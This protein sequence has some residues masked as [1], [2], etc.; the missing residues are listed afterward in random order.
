MASQE[1]TETI[2]NKFRHLSNEA[3]VARIN[4]LP[5][6]GWDDE[7]F[8]I[9]RRVKES[10]GSLVVKMDGNTLVIIPQNTAIDLGHKAQDGKEYFDVVLDTAN[11]TWAMYKNSSCLAV[12][13]NHLAEQNNVEY[14][15]AQGRFKVFF[16]LNSPEPIAERIPKKYHKV[17]FS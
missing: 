10:N 11:N 4:K 5:D 9:S 2:K 14:W 13:M 16:N 15:D 12:L 7:G 3:L 6:F 1:L 17:I 8:E